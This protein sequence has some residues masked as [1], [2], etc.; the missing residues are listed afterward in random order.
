[1]AICLKSGDMV[2][3]RFKTVELIDSGGQAT[4]YLAIDQTNS[5][6]VV[7]KQYFFDAVDP[8]CAQQLTRARRAAELNLPPQY[9]A[10]TIAHSIEGRTFFHI[11][12]YIEG[13]TLE[14]S[15][16]N[17]KIFSL[18]QI[19]DILLQCCAV[20]SLAHGQGVAHSD[21]NPSNIMIDS[22]GHVRII[23]WGIC[24]ERN[25]L[26]KP[27]GTPGFTAPET[28]KHGYINPRTDIYSLGLTV[29]KLLT[30]VHPFEATT[31][32]LM[33]QKILD[34]NVLPPGQMACGIP[35]AMDTLV[36]RMIARNPDRRFQN[37]AELKKAI[38]NM[39][40]DDKPVCSVCSMPLGIHVK[41]CP[42]CGA[43]TISIEEMRKISTAEMVYP[44]LMVESITG[45]KRSVPVVAERLPLNRYSLD[46]SNQAISRSHAEITISN[47]RYLIQ[48]LRSRNGTYVNGQKIT[49]PHT[50]TN[51]DV[52]EMGG[53]K[54]TFADYPQKGE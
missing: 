8:R 28:I 32:E 39:S 47:G 24:Y 34:G 35:P 3:G 41:F 9:T 21:I 19:L 36:M 1:M 10:R 40:L 22:N 29:Y 23:D 4:V 46:P 25:S 43:R 48:D 37:I 16:A 14:K 52:I 6:K 5:C 7:V 11:T 31:I 54:I 42:K 20:L 27:G 13:E 30:G 38:K 53:C 33:E 12:E 15:L 49:D 45:A 26:D 2:L 17:G 44:A 18:R 50:L 51:G